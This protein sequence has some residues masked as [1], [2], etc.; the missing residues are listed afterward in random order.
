MEV[1]VNYW[2][3]LLAT[4]SSMVVGAVWYMPG[5]F[6]NTWM[7]LT[8]VK[9]D[10]K[11]SPKDSVV[12]YSLTFVASLLTA[13]ILA[14]VTFLSNHFFHHDFLQDALT[15]AFWL[16]LGF[17][18][19]RFIVHDIFEGRRKKLTLINAGHELLTVMVMG[20]IIGLMGV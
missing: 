20:L 17:T 5:I 1:I 16:W 12:T 13:Y 2:A 14:H 9:M 10:K 19:A 11:M 15:T 4:L 7:K 8:G 6:G 18:F 3:V